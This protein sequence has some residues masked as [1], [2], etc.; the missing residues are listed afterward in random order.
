MNTTCTRIKEELSSY[1]DNETSSMV[2]SEIAD[3]LL[4]CEC[5]RQECEGLRAVS[6]LL[7]K[8]LP[9]EELPIPDIWGQVS[10]HL[11]NMCEVI[12]DDLSAYLDGELPLSAQEGINSHLK[13][14]FNCRDKFKK[15]NATNQLIS[16]ALELPQ[17]LIVDLWGGVKSRL[18]AD[19]TLIRSELSVFVDQ[20][21]A[22]LRHRTITRH[23]LECQECQEEF[24]GLSQMGD[25]I[26]THYQP[27]LPEDFDLWTG[28]KRAIN[29]I[30]IT[31]GERSK[32]N[33]GTTHARKY[34]VLLTAAAVAVGLVGTL[35]FVTNTVGNQAVRPV[36]A[37]SYLLESAMAEPADIAEA[38]VYE[39]Q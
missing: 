10:A 4:E 37:E 15:L 29:V 30:P 22:T 12:N 23:L 18:N 11:P 31:T 28:I 26:R 9:G 7:S 1:L 39:N 19:C 5:C 36:S 14:C 6:Q 3:H 2:R 16:K 20:E 25:L 34:L 24:N 35:T 8:K 38:V 21:V 33:L 13:E 27:V 32:Q 17:T